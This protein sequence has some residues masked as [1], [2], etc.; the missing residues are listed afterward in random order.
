MRQTRK[1]RDVS[2]EV[3]KNEE[4]RAKGEERNGEEPKAPA[5]PEEERK[6][7]LYLE[8]L[9]RQLAAKRCRGCGVRGNWD[10]HERKPAGGRIVRINCKSCR[11]PDHVVVIVKEPAADEVKP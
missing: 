11:R 5:T 1:E 10:V 8:S 9:N 2:K 3:K 7:R 4:R 6:R